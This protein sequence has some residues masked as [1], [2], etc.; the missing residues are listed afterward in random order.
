MRCK[1]TRPCNA[2]KGSGTSPAHETLVASQFGKRENVETGLHDTRLA[3]ALATQSRLRDPLM[4]SQRQ[5]HCSQPA[6]NASGGPTHEYRAAEAPAFRPPAAS[7]ASPE[8]PT[9]LRHGRVC[10]SCASHQVGRPHV[11]LPHPHI[12]PELVGSAELVGDEG[13]GDEGAEHQVGLVVAREHP[14]EALDASEEPL[15][16]VVALVQ[17]GIVGPRVGSSLSA[18]PPARSRA[19]APGSASRRLRKHG[20]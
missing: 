6:D 9:R 17:V 4:P 10:R 2:L 12:Y 16:L 18:A 20:P 1:R 11:A 19:T 8:V 15:D 3:E 5:Q 13:D 7:C 14:P